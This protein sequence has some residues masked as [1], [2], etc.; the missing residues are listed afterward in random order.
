MAKR[1]LS[2]YI[3]RQIV[4][5]GLVDATEHLLDTAKML[6]GLAR[7]IMDEEVTTVNPSQLLE[8]GLRCI[9]TIELIV[10]SCVPNDDAED[11]KAQWEESDTYEDLAQVRERMNR[12]RGKILGITEEE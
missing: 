9:D 6:G 7:M 5:Q 3:M 8:A 10:E 11:Y 2:Q 1:E 4:S 12:L